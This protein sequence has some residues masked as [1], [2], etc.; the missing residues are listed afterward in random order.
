MNKIIKKVLST[1]E[2]KGFEAYLVG[3]YVRDLLLGKISYDID[4]CTNATPKE[5]I[6]IFPTALAKS[7]GGIDFK[8]K[9]YHFEIMTYREEIKYKNRR[10][11]EYNYINNLVLDLQRRDFTINAICMN[12]KG[13][14]IDLVNGVNDL[15]NNKIVMIGNASLKLKEDPLRILRAIRFA[16]VLNLNLD[17]NLVKEIKNNYKEIKTLSSTRVKEEFDKILL[18]HYV[19]KGLTLLKDYHILDLLDITYDEIIP[20]KSIEGMYAQ[21][22]FKYDFPFTT[23]ERNNIKKIKEILEANEITR[24]TLYNYGLYLTIVAGEIL[25]VSNKT[26]NKMFKELPIHEKKDINIKSEEIIKILDINYGKKISVIMNELESLILNGT[27]KNKK[28]DIIK[29]IINNKARWENE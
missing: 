26:I 20:V 5:L 29:Y 8:V 16:A 3:G 28:N 1:I 4:I 24:Q 19:K 10:P 17:N 23:Y 9:E 12:S 15:T 11:S 22:N 14:I 18:S 2:K 25:G 6:A 21:L 27:L 7:L 13:E